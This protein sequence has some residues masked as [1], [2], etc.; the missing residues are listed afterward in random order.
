MTSRRGARLAGLL[1]LPVGTTSPAGRPAVVLC[2]GMESTKEGTKHQALAARLTALGYVCLRFDFSYVGESEGRFEDL[3]I[4]GEV[5]DLG[6]V[7]DFLSARGVATFGLVGSSLGG[8]VAVLFAG[9]D[10]R[11][12][13]L[14]TIAAV[15][16]PLGIVER[17]GSAAAEAWRRT[18]V[19]VIEGGARLG[20]AF[21]D[22]LER[23][24]VVE[25]A[26]RLT[27]ATL[28][29]HGDSDAVV[30]VA[31]ASALFAA[32][33]EPKALAITPA[34]DHRYSDP[35]HLDALIDRTID[36]MTT[37]LPLGSPA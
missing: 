8:T 23:L 27:A 34:C 4:S 32:L 1:H 20:R 24:D 31:D 6:G 35:A 22:D 12:R 28:V 11:V 29:T 36:W 14:V 7:V 17:M 15:A 33:P 5:E 19:R 3:T 37:R 9:D 13:A 25:A 18:G 16:L 26:R 30:P 10:P 2:H 21:L